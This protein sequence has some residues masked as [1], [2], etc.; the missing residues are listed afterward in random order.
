MLK[1]LLIVF[2]VLL[3][4]ILVWYFRSPL[5]ITRFPITK[6][7]DPVTLANKTANYY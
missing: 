2:A 5:F 3:V 6:G 1:T 7:L 4:V